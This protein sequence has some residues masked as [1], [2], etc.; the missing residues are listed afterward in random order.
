MVCPSKILRNNRRLLSFLLRKLEQ[1]EK[2]KIDIF[3]FMNAIYIK[4]KQNSTNIV[5]NPEAR[6]VPLIA[7]FKKSV[8]SWNEEKGFLQNEI[9]RP[10]VKNLNIFKCSIDLLSTKFTFGK[11]Y[12]HRFQVHFILKPIQFM[13]NPRSAEEFISQELCDNQKPFNFDDGSEL[14]FKLEPG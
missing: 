11:G 3:S 12:T 2:V 7:T 5:T 4:S 8:V 1:K 6:F 14:F 10:K 13:E 9:I